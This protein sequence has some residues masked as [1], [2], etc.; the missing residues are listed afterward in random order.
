MDKLVKQLNIDLEK[1]HEERTINNRKSPQQKRSAEIKLR[2][3]LNTKLARFNERNYS[4]DNHRIM[5]T[6]PDP[7]SQ[8]VDT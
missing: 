7:A 8:L 2:K 1:A 6:N 3:T 4:L 5:N